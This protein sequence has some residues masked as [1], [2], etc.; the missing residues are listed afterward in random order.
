MT[1][2]RPPPPPLSRLAC[3]AALALLTHGAAALAADIKVI[4]AAAV[5]VPVT[6]L[7]EQFEKATGHRVVFEFSTAGGV[8]SKVRG[9]ARNDL[10]INAAE[11][12]KGLAADGLVAPAARSLGV[13]RMGVAVRKGGKVP[14]LSSA[15]SFRAS[16]LGA[17]SIAYGD[18]AR[19]ATTG[20]HFGKMLDKLGIGD[21]VRGKSHL[22]ANG[23]EVMQLVTN[24][25]AEIG[26]TQISEI[27]HV[28]GDTLVGLLPA[29]LQLAS[30]YGVALGSATPGT[31]AAQFADLLVSAEGSAR[32]RHAGFD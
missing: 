4:S 14:D 12:L 5:Q 17:D 20:I 23:L 25:K 28:K 1:A 3:G 13:V 19:G 24:G 27:L 15:A 32:F 22:A 2:R 7:A 16:L 18:P 26:V 29:E 9:G 6:E 21:A 11:R 31:A 30:N 10:V 8:E